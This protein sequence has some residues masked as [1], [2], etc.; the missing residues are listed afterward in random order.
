MER[1][2]VGHEVLP[3]QR[4]GRVGIGV[5]PD[6]LR[7]GGRRAQ[8]RLDLGLGAGLDDGRQQGVQNIAA[9]GSVHGQRGSVDDFVL[10]QQRDQLGVG[11]AVADAVGDHVDA[12]RGGVFRARD[13]D[14]MRQHLETAAA[15]L[16]DDGGNGL[17]R[18]G[19]HRGGIAVT[20]TVGEQLQDV[21]IVGRDRVDHGL[22]VVGGEDF[23]GEVVAATAFHAVTERRGDARGEMNPGSLNDAVGDQA[24]HRLEHLR[25]D[26][27][28]DDRGHAA[29]QVSRQVFGP[30]AGK[31]ADRRVGQMGVEVEEPRQQGLALGVDD[32]PIGLESEG[33][34]D[35]DDPIAAKEHG[36][37]VG[38]T[39]GAIHDGR[40]DNGGL[41]AQRQRESQR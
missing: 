33:G 12:G 5:V 22:G 6:E 16:L 1:A 20:P 36:S 4:A 9:L 10:E 21:G 26:A 38:R 34:G 30:A 28:L 31:P 17:A 7:V 32:G 19:G 15:G 14:G 37:A 8:R 25:V 18:H 40:S 23:V 3:A 13:G 41:G 29:V 35:F 2:V 39:A 11:G 24:T 27:E